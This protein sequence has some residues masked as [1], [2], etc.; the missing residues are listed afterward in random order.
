M[1]LLREFNPFHRDF[2]LSTEHGRGFL[3]STISLSSAMSVSMC[4]RQAL[5]SS[6]SLLAW[7]I[8]LERNFS[9]LSRRHAL[10]FTASICNVK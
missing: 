7:T 8:S 3:L 1:A 10:G 6:I 4:L 9:F 2:S 5:A